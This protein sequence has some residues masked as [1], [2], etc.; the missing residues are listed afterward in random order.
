MKEIKGAYSGF[1]V[2]GC[3]WEGVE[4]KGS[5]RVRGKADWHFRIMERHRC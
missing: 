2:P 5:H 3:V 4:E 1:P